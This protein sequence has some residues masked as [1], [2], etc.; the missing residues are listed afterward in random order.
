MQHKG[1]LVFPGIGFPPLGKIGFTQVHL[2]RDGGGFL[3]VDHL[4]QTDGAHAV[5]HQVRVLHILV[6]RLADAGAQIVFRVAD[7]LFLQLF[8]LSVGDGG[9]GDH[10]R[11]NENRSPHPRRQGDQSV[12]NEPEAE[13]QADI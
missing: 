10:R 8:L 2:H 5:I 1:P 9:D 12:L 6:Q 7:D 11:Q 3:R 13:E 4:L